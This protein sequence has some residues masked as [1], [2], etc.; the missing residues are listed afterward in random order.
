MN[1]IAAIVSREI[2]AAVAAAFRRDAAIRE[3]PVL[4][5]VIYVIG[6]VI[7]LNERRGDI[8]LEFYRVRIG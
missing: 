8:G 7:P 4:G 1:L 6:P 5:V 3:V 2:K